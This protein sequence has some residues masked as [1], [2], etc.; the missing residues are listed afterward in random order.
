MKRRRPCAKRLKALTV[1][2]EHRRNSR[3]HLIAS[4]GDHLVVEAAAAALASLSDEPMP[5]KSVA[6][7][8]TNSGAAITYD[9][10]IHPLALRNPG[11]TGA[12]P[13]TDESLAPR[14]WLA[15]G[16]CAIQ[17]HT[18]RRGGLQ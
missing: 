9:M 11:E 16:Y 1:R 14:V 5:A 3:R 15:F 10:S 8:V 7:A 12:W 13:G 6:A 18:S 4:G 2:R 17:P